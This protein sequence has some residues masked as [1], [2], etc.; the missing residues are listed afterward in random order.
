[1]SLDQQARARRQLRVL[2]AASRG[3]A[4]LGAGAEQQAV[5]LLQ[6]VG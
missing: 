3:A 4:V 6:V 2:V 1:M 5:V